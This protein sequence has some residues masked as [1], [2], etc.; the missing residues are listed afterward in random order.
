MNA[1]SWRRQAITGLASGVPLE[2]LL[3]R[4]DQLYHACPQQSETFPQERNAPEVVKTGQLLTRSTR[5]QHFPIRI[6]FP[7]KE[8]SYQR[9]ISTKEVPDVMS[10]CRK[11]NMSVVVRSKSQQ[12]RN[13]KSRNKSNATNKFPIPATKRQRRKKTY[14]SCKIKQEIRFREADTLAR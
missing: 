12:F 8:K 4:A 7:T 6:R 9:S 1:V 3:K 13:K 2:E 5:L 14:S 11:K 10:R